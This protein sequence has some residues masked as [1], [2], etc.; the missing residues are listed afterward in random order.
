MFIDKNSIALIEYLAANEPVKNSHFPDTFYPV[1]VLTSL[2]TENKEYWNKEYL[3]SYL[4]TLKTNGL[5]SQ[6]IF[7]GTSSV[8]IDRTAMLLNYNEYLASSE[9]NVGTQ[10]NYPKNKCCIETNPPKSSFDRFKDA[11]KTLTAVMS[12]IITIAT[13]FEYVIR[14]L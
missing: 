10:N 5:I 12:T 8:H 11:F 7:Y 13:F 9:N 6:Y 3:D 4:A 14:F 1:A 2:L